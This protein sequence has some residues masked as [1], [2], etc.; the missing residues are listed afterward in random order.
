LR[1]QVVRG[2]HPSRGSEL[3]INPG[4]RDAKDV[5]DSRGFALAQSG[6]GSRPLSAATGGLCEIGGVIGQPFERRP[7][8]GG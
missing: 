3:K 1:G 2:R 4:G 8:V 5:G 7:P 6:C